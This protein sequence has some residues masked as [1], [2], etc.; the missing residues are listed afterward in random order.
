[1]Q[2]LLGVEL[3]QNHIHNV[4]KSPKKVSILQIYNAV[5]MRLFK[6]ISN[7]V[8]IK[9][10]QVST[11]QKLKWKKRPKI[12]DLACQRHLGTQKGLESE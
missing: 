7:T 8:K 1:M 4:S 2:S 12:D 11:T 5:K 10:K 3:Q 9:I 6:L